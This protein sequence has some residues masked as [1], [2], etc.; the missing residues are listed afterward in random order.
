MVDFGLLKDLLGRV[1]WDKA[2]EERGAQKSFLILKVQFY[3]A[4]GW[5]VPMGR[6][7][8]KNARCSF[9]I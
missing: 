2:M 8:S 7:L 5:S 4:Q 1:P 3:Q 6:K 9:K